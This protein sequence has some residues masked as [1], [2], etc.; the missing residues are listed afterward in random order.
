MKNNRAA[1]FRWGD[2]L[3]LGGFGWIFPE[4]WGGGN[5]PWQIPEVSPLIAGRW[6][7]PHPRSLPT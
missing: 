4:Q 2:F 7:V 6:G 3:V 5:P 1:L